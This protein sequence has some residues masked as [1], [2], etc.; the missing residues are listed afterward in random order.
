MSG[1]TSRRISAVAQHD[2]HEVDPRAELAIRDG[3]HAQGLLHR[4]RHFAAD[5]EAGRP[6]V[7]R[8]QR[9]LGQQLGQ[10]VL[11]QGFD[12]AIELAAVADDAEAD[13]RALRCR[14]AVPGACSMPLTLWLTKP[15][16]AEICAQSKPS[17]RELGARDFHHFDVQQDLVH[18]AD[19]SCR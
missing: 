7:E 5:V 11:P 1:R 8:D 9:R 2:R 12:E 10:V 6:A 18:A 4:N 15:P 19:A 14:S 17:V 3:G 16:P 13:G